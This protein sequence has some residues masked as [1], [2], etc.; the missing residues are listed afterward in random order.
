MQHGGCTGSHETAQ[1]SVMPAIILREPT[2]IDA[3][4]ITHLVRNSKPLDVNS[5]YAYLLLC[6]HFPKTCVVAD[7]GSQIVGFLSGYRPP[8]TPDVIFVWQVAVAAE[9]RGQGLAGRLLDELLQRDACSG[10]S[11]L[12][13]TVSPSN[14][15]SEALFRKLAQRLETSCE[16]SELFSEELF[17]GVED[18]EPE[19][20][21]R[22][23]PFS[24]AESQKIG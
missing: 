21:F 1:E 19:V 6:H 15:A 18:H 5:H 13:T 10:V 24:Q 14:R 11:Y 20:L 2:P 17:A 8:D 16:T 4:R 22:I 7:S 9:A 3:P 23:G 12:E